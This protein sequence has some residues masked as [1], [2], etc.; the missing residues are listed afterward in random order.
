[1]SETLENPFEARAI[2]ASSV[3]QP[4]LRPSPGRQEGS[5]GQVVPHRWF[6][7]GS[8]C[9]QARLAFGSTVQRVCAWACACAA[10]RHTKAAAIVHPT[11]PRS[12]RERSVI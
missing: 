2:I 3:Y 11:N 4:A 8:I 7:C 9:H 12:E 10:K 6:R 1:M 5:A